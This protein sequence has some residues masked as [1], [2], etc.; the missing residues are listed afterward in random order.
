MTTTSALK[1]LME[2]IEKAWPFD[3]KEYPAL[4]GNPPQE[5]VRDFAVRHI[6]Y[7][8]QKAATRMAEICETKD[9]EGKITA[10]DLELLRTTVRKSFINTLRLAAMLEIPAGE[11]M[12]TAT[13]WA[14]EKLIPKA[15][16]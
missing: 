16:D 13:N 12:K 14:T 5:V 11:L 4:R 1:E 15:P 10:E 2:L 7:H 9:H 8:Q 3:G 6:M